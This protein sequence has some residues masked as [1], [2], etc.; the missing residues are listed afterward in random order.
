MEDWPRTD[1]K[2]STILW[3]DHSIS[4]WC[5][6]E[7]QWHLYEYTAITML[8]TQSLRRTFRGFGKNNIIIITSAHCSISDNGVEHDHKQTMAL[9]KWNKGTDPS[10]VYNG[11]TISMR[12]GTPPDNTTDLQV[13][14]S[15]TI[16]HSSASSV[17]ILHSSISMTF[18]NRNNND[19][20]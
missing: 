10:A 5:A 17:T 1:T 20:P 9:H 2:A 8:H 4:A 19:I 12:V 6:T 7:T 15:V 18:G 14:S 3:L 13:K 16:L 11:Q